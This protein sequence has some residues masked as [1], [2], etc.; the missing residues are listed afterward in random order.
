MVVDLNQKITQYPVVDIFAG[1]GGLGEGFASV[2]S[3]DNCRRFDS[4]LS[5]ENEKYSYQTLLLRHFLRCFDPGEEPE[6]YYQY[7]SGELTIDEIYSRYSKHHAEAKCKVQQIS[8][9]EN[10]HEL[11]RQI[12]ES[13]LAGNKYWVL[14][15]GPPC[16]AYSLAGR[17]RMK[18]NENFELDERHFLYKEYLNILSDHKPPVFVMENVKGLLSA[19]VGDNSTI[20][21]IIDDLNCPEAAL[22]RPISGFRYR[23]YSLTNSESSDSSIDPRRFLVKAEQFG[24]PQA[25][26]RIFIVG[27]RSDLCITPQT[28]VPQDPPTVLQTIG[29]LPSIRSGLSRGKDSA[30][31]WQ[32]KVKKLAEL[33]LKNLLRE[34]SNSVDIA[35]SISKLAN[36]EGLPKER[37]STIYPRLP[38][39]EHASILN[40][41]DHRLGVLD[42]HEARA[43]MPS[44]L[45][46]YMYAATFAEKNDKSPKLQ[47]FTTIFVN[48]LRNG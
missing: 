35:L 45:W 21:M 15:G 23:L 34:V 3:Y 44:D 26:H 46:R 41:F 1:P 47:E 22:N 25:R 9:H 17:S 29:N 18:G 6:E 37:F 33:N 27:V 42:G 30:S 7:L 5:I 43:H 19:K 13:R 24:V 11:V 31:Q 38:E 12:I 10:N 14:V 8:L 40:M 20:Q 32:R 39:S 48:R 36:Y 4:I 28:L 2:L 16:Q